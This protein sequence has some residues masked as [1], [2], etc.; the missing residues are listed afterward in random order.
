MNFVDLADP[1]REA[2]FSEL[3]TTAVEGNVPYPWVAINGQIKLAGSAHYYNVLPHVEE[4]LQKEGLV[5][6][7]G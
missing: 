5:A 4:V 1:D 6:D 7:T 2:E 3:V